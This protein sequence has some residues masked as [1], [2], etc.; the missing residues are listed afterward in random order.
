M[1][2]GV[3]GRRHARVIV[4]RAHELRQV[5]PGRRRRHAERDGVRDARVVVVV[6]SR[7]S[8]D[9][10]WR[11]RARRRSSRD[12]DDN[13]PGGGSR[14]LLQLLHL[15]IQLVQGDGGVVGA[16]DAVEA[17]DGLRRNLDQERRERVVFSR[18]QLR[19]QPG[20]LHV[21]AADELHRRTETQ[22][23]C[24]THTNTIHEMHV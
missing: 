23:T 17:R 6:G 12:A 8:D 14:A 11:W 21:L 16:I 3:V 13:V 19:V 1:V 18:R 2:V 9:D 24:S 15:V 5:E 22:G 10:A 4:I 7:G 20:H